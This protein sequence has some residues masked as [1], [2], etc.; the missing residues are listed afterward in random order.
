MPNTL[1]TPTERPRFYEQ[2]YLGASDLTD[3]VDYARVARARHDLGAHTWGIAAGLQIVE[4][5]SK[6]GGPLEV[7]VEPG[8]A[9]DGFGRPISVLAP[10]RVPASLFESLP[11]ENSDG[12]QPPGRLVQLWIGYCESVVGGPAPGFEICN[13][14]D[15]YDRTIETY[16]LVIGAF[17]DHSSHDAINVGGYNIDARDVLARFSIPGPTVGGVVTVAALDDE[18]VPYQSLPVDARARWLVPLGVVRWLPANGGN[19]GGFQPRQES[20][21][22]DPLVGPRDLTQS[23][24]FRRYAGVVAS[25]IN[26]AGDAIRLRSRTAKLEPDVWSKD[27]VWMEGSTRVQGDVTLMGGK[28]ALRDANYADRG[29]PLSVERSE[30]NPTNGRDLLLK[31]GVAESGANRLVV[32]PMIGAGAAAKVHEKL[33][34]KDDGKVGIGEPNP[35]RPL[36]VRAQGDNDDAVG[37]QNK[38]GATKWALALNG[39][40]TPGF[41]IREAASQRT[42]LFVKEGGNVGIGTQQPTNHLHVQG[43]PGLRVNDL[44]VSG[45]EGNPSSIAYNFYRDANA[46]GANFPD[47][48]QT[49]ITIELDQFDGTP[50]FEV[51][52]T[53]VAQKQGFVQRLRISGDTGDVLV[54]HNG[55]NVGI[56]TSS[57]LSKTHI[58]GNV[59]GSPTQLASHVSI[60]ENLATGAD[61]NVLAL[62]VRESNPSF[63]NFITFFANNTAIG[64]IDGNPNGSGISFKSSGA[65]VAEWMPRAEG[66]RP[67]GAGDIV[68]VRNGML[69][70]QL[71]GAEHLMVISTAPMVLGNQPPA[72]QRSSFEPVA[73]LGRTPVRVRGPV[74]RGDYILADTRSDGAGVAVA[75]DTLTLDDVPRIVGIAWEDGAGSGVQGVRCGVGLPVSARVWSLLGAGLRSANKPPATPPTAARKASPSKAPAAAVKRPGKSPSRTRKN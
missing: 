11:F 43:G 8:Y 66:E 5:P 36:V 59:S 2:Q 27:L 67:M 35:D 37:L 30:S 17:P 10:V 49:A 6:I 73:F 75:F 9:W 20:A 47:P 42:R 7:Y 58:S 51:W 70:R 28:L 64:S 31:I 57:P 23:E 29:A 32:G 41:H 40:N 4:Q 74:K 54:A 69:S 34:V 65:D 62:R 61:S 14:N 18:S 13:I 33:V 3:I 22:P 72:D 68:G 39:D 60:I 38:S 50:R 21:N 63:N 12:L 16:Q 53:T 56:G 26:A 19:S 25:T 52:S 24:R 55:G 15:Q 1:P 44:Y 46:S 48:A 71:E 45:G